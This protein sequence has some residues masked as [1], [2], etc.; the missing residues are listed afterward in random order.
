MSCVTGPS[1][2][3]P[4]PAATL[5]TSEQVSASFGKPLSPILS[6]GVSA[7]PALKV[8]TDVIQED[9]E[10]PPQ[11]P[12]KS[13]AAERKGSPSPLKLNTKSS[14]PQLTTPASTTPGTMFSGNVF[15]TRRSPNVNAPLPTPLSASSNPFSVA[16]PSIAVDHRASPK[17]EKRDLMASYG[18][19]NRNLSES[20]VM[21]RGRPV[22]RSSKRSRSRTASE[23]NNSDEPILDNWQLPKGMRAADASR[24]MGKAEKDTLYKQASAQAD[25]FEVMNKRDVASMSRVCKP[26]IRTVPGLSLTAVRQELRAL[27]ERC[28]YLR[29]T[30]KSLRAGRQKL[31][32]RMISYLKRGNTV[33]FSRESLLKQ[34]EA[35]AELDVSIDEF[36]LKLEQ[37]ENRRLRL[38]QKLLEHLAAALLLNPVTQ[39]DGSETTPPRS[40]VKAESPSRIERKEVESI[41]IYADG[42]V[43]SLFSDIEH[44]IGKMCEQ[45]Y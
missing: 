36:I 29:K 24:R 1:P 45:A 30:Y 16:S 41:K 6:P 34:E 44:A 26:I 12:P 37:A 23:T 38:R 40:P 15:D 39:C 4:D 22:R 18:A 31:H 42:H 28:D 17:V 20:S 13:P 2:A 10:F 5:P 43:L 25:K 11:V 3:Q 33:I 19:H 9:G 32:G 21:D 7:R 27:D 14:R 8:D 35:L